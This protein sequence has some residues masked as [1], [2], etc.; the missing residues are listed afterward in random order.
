MHTSSNLW[1][2]K[3]KWKLTE[4]SNKV[5][6]VETNLDSASNGDSV[7]G[8]GPDWAELLSTRSEKA[9]S[10]SSGRYPW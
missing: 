2:V 6:K 7:L 9:A 1:P 8:M 3:K 4:L 10:I 5:K